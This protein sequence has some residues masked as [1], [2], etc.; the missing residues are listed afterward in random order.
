MRT[1]LLA[2]LSLAVPATAGDF[3]LSNPIDCDLD[4]PCFI[5]QY[6]DHDPSGDASDFACSGLSYDGHKGTDFALPTDD[7]IA[8]GVDV[9]ATADGVV[10]GLRDGMDDVRYSAE[11]AASVEGREC[12]NGLVLRHA[13]GWETQYCHLRRGSVT[14]TRGQKIEAGDVVGQ[15]GMSGRAEFPHLHLS[16]RKD[17][18]VVDP[19]EPDGKITCGVVEEDTLWSDMPS[20][21]AGGIISIGTAANVPEFSAIRANTVPTPAPDS[22]ALVIYAFMF[23][24]QKGDVIRLALDGPTGEVIA[25]DVLLKRAQAQSFRAIGKKRRGTQWAAGTYRGTATLLR[26][27]QVIDQRDVTLSLP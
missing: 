27:K 10:A 25:R 9:L 3:S 26:G 22:D 14:V 17:G 21:R 13:D 11:T 4:G 24:T 5:Q 19:F 1:T 12:G 15:V 6:V 18:A 2:F 16:V 8:E 7:M 23:G 20:Y